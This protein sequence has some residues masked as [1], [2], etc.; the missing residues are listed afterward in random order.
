MKFHNQKGHTLLEMSLVLFIIAIV[1]SI[2]LINMNAT[3]DATIRNQFVYQLQQDLYYAQ[4]TAINK[5]APT[6]VIFY[7]GTKEYRVLLE[8]KVILRREFPNVDTR[9]IQGSLLLSDITFLSNGN[10]RKS[11]SLTFTI[12]ES[13]YRLV[14]LL[15]RGRFYIEQL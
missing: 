2:S 14:L 7:N 11:G 13:R 8:G 3:V 10:N 6:T 12:G 4:Q 15:G 1:S 5:Q 9:F